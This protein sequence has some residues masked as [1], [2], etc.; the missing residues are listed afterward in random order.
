[1][2]SVLDFSFLPSDL[3]HSETRPEPKLCEKDLSKDESDA[4]PHERLSA[5]EQLQYQLTT[6]VLQT[7]G[8]KS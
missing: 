6:Q 5:L 2:L 3:Q 1:M 7:A 8:H 4:Q